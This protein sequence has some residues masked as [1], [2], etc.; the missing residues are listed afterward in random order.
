[1]KT[2]VIDGVIGKGEGEISS[3]MVL[4]QLPEDGS[5]IEVKI[6]SEGGDVFEGFRVHDVFANYPGEKRIKIESSA[7][8]IAS[9]IPMA[10]DDIEITPNGYMMIHNPYIEVEGDS[11]ELAR[12]AKQLGQFKDNMVAAYAKRSGKT[13]EEISALC[14]QETFLNAE[15]CV[16]MGF[17]NRITPTAVSGRVFAKTKNL[18]HGVVAALFGE[19]VNGNNDK[20]ENISMSNTQKV[21]ATVK[22]IKSAYPKA[23]TEFIV[24]CMEKEM[25]MEDVAAEYNEEL[26]AENDTLSAK[27]KAMEEELQALK[28]KAMEEEEIQAKAKAMEEEE[29]AEAKARA[30]SGIKPVAKGHSASNVSARAAWFAAVNAKV[31]NGLPK[32]KAIIEVDQEDPTLRQRLLD[33]V[34]A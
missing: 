9:F 17:A 23:K 10:F 31:A 5:P 13:A 11:E 32:A 14:E 7:F 3:S 2:I 21:A 30:K 8:S 4:S 19:A 15:Q 28:A 29:E 22:Q 26:E 18:P 6:H 1:M 12:R 16:A 33:E 25:A 34:N 20:Q 27:V 24:R